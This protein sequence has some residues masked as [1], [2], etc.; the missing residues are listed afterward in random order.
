MDHQAFA[1]LLGNY[2]EFLGAIAVVVTLVYLAAQIRQNT[3]SA[4]A[5]S[6]DSISRST[7][8]IL[9]ANSSDPE[10]A[11]FFFTGLM[12]PDALATADLA[13]RFD[14]MIYAVFE[15]YE[16]AF[17]QWNRGVLSDADWQKWSRIIANYMKAPGV[18]KAWSSRGLK[19][20]LTP[21]FQDYVEGLGDAEGWSW[22]RDE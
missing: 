4:Q 9:L 16:A 8:D 1:Q 18:Q 14:M 7:I 13:F 22:Y 3:K 6:R 10:T 11:K 17:A 2:G 19:D 12:N 21:A 15:S 5:A 20:A